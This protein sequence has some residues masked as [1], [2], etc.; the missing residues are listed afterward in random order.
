MKVMAVEKVTTQVVSRLDCVFW[1]RGMLTVLIFGYLG[2]NIIVIACGVCSVELKLWQ[3][4]NFT[5]WSYI[6]M[7]LCILDNV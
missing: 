5:A 7:D 4:T 3:A 2:M 6:A 1:T